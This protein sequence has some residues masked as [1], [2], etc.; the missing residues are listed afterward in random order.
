MDERVIPTPAPPGWQGTT[1]LRPGWLAFS[2]E[3]GVTGP[4]AH[5]A[6]QVLVVTAGTVDVTDA[7]RTCLRVRAAIIPPRARHAVRGGPGARA[8]MLY[9]DPAG[10]AS[11][12]LL[13]AVTWPRHDRVADWVAAADTL[14]PAGE[15]TAGAPGRLG[16]DVTAGDPGRPDRDVTVGGLRDPGALVRGWSAPAHG[17]RHPALLRALALLPDLLAG[18]VRLTDLAAAV[19]LSASRLGHLFT[20]ELGLPYPVYVRWLRLRRAMELARQGAGLTEA[21]HGAGFADSSHL[22]RAC[23]EMFGL[24]PSRLVHVVRA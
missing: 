17:P 11:R 12:H 19:H 8:E 21:A 22:T 20:A 16:P 13:T 9:L 24:A 3:V 23:H 10:S 4:H 15:E 2:G 6:L 18:P 7:H 5:A 14:L 1:T